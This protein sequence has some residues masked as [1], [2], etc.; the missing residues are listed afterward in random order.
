MREVRPADL[1]GRRVLLVEDHPLNLR[2]AKTLLEREQVVVECAMD[3]LQAVRTF[4]ASEPGY[5]DGVLMDIRMP[6]MDGLEATRVIR[7]SSHPDG[8]TVPIIAM[9][10]NAFDE[11]VKK[12]LDAGMNAHLAK[13]I[14]PGLMFGTLSRY[15]GTRV[16]TKAR[17]KR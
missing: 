2:I 12:S 16:E 4:G 5:Y 17:N 8:A 7:A 10:A 13:P 11:D 14:D 1:A 6:A 3:G 9:S 15:I